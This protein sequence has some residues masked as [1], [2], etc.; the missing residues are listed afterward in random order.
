MLVGLAVL[1]AA[2]SFATQRWFTL[3]LLDLSAQAASLGAVQHLMPWLAAGGV[4]VA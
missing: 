1:A 4:L 3:P 2:L